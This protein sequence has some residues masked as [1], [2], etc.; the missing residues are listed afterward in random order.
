MRK[1]WEPIWQ[2]GIGWKVEFSINGERV[3][4]RLGIRDRRLRDIARAK[5]KDIYRETW[6]RH[7][8]PTEVKPGIPFFQAARGYIEA[9]GEARFLPR[10]ISHFGPD[11]MID[12][13]TEAVIVAAG[14]AVYPGCSTDT[15]RRQVRVP[16]SAVL[17]WSRGER[18]HQSTDRAR[19]RW[20]LPEEAERL[21]S[22]CATLTL[23]RHTTPEHFTL[24]KVA[25]LL[26]SGCRTGECFTADVR[27]WNPATR[28][29]W[30]SG[31]ESGAGKTASSARMVRLPQRAVDLIGDIPEVGR[32][33]RTPYGKPIKMR[34]N[35]GG[36]MQTAFRAAIKAA[37]LADEGPMKVTPH[38]LRHTWATW[39]YAQTRDF[40]ALMDLGG[41]SK[42]DMAN[43]YRKL[44]P[45]DL[46]ER[47]LAR[48]WDFRQDFGKFTSHSGNIYKIQQLK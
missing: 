41:W 14:E 6:R 25:F 17:R 30:I 28:Q 11:T 40:G 45:D 9:G 24:Q 4:R 34:E 13:I 22:A 47:L 27:D 20:L 44:A 39:F 35:G 31:T 46:A 23:P 43:R 19:L 48:G 21:I 3:R 15:I 12:D 32:A 42:A 36:Q 16:I 38:V 26:G 37:G 8:D 2:E 18:R 1:E 5:A 7:L 29:W 10:L 33:F